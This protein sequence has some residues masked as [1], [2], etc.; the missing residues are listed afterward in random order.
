MNCTPSLCSN[1]RFSV[2]SVD[3]ITEIDEPVEIPQVVQ[4]PKNQMP[5]QPTWFSWEKCLPRRLV[6]AA[7]EDGPRSLKL[8]VDIETTDT[9]EVKSLQSLVDSGATGLFID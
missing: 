7:L 5:D 4:T 2:L 3:S 6:I 8:N 9:G 1:N